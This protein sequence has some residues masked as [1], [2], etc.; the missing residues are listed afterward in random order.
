[1]SR[2]SPCQLLATFVQ[3]FLTLSRKQQQG[4][5]YLKPTGTTL[6]A[7]KTQFATFRSSLP[8]L[9]SVVGAKNSQAIVSTLDQANIPRLLAI[10]SNPEPAL[11]KWWYKNVSPAVCSAK[12]VVNGS[13]VID[14]GIK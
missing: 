6:A 12:L 4:R 8:G 3:D 11:V 13:F 14:S 5:S 2:L 10:G 7:L 9:L 1:M